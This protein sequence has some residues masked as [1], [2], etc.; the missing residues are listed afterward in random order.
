MQ[1]W[2]ICA[3]MVNAALAK[4]I[5]ELSHAGLICTHTVMAVLS[6][7]E[8]PTS[9]SVRNEENLRRV[10]CADTTRRA[11]ETES[12]ALCAQQR[13]RKNGAMGANTVTLTQRAIR[14][15]EDIDIAQC[16]AGN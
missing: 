15:W 11:A 3:N 10:M 6:G 1:R 13:R 7:E 14:L 2:M 5:T 8:L 12:H 16:A 4:I 9:A